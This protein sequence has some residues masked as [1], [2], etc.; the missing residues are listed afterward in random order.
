[1]I[2]LVAANIPD[3]DVISLAGGP[4]SYLHYHRHLTH[5]LIAMPVMAAMAV[6]LVWAVRRKPLAWSGAFAVALAG[7]ASHLL[8]DWTNM[9][10]VRL[11]LPFS[12]QWQRLDLN[13]VVDL[14]IWAAFLLGIAGPFIGRLVGGEIS[15]GALKDRHPGRG[16]AIFALVFLLLYDGGRAMLHTRAVATLES[17][18]YQGASPARVAALP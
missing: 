13:S 18:I 5:S 6:A 9:Y 1:P 8:M 7:V 4:L 16:G 10:G 15:S 14:W 2:L 3:I 11:L 17:R 12:P